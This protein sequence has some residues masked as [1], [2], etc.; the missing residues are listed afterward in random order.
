MRN[1]INCKKFDFDPGHPDWSE[2]TPGYGWEAKCI[3]GKWYMQGVS[4]DEND[5][6]TTTRQAENCD[7]F[8]LVN[9][10]TK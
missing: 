8:E 6:R 9:E 4:V 10:T 2:Y 5:W 3:G 1:C 7:E